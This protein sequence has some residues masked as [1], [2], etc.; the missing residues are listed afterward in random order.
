MALTIWE[1]GIAGIGVGLRTN[2]DAVLRDMDGF[3]DGA[4][5]VAAPR[6]ANELLDRALLTGERAVRDVYAL[7]LATIRKRSIITIKRARRGDLE[8]SFNVKGKGFALVDFNPRQT[9]NGVAVTIKG[10]R[11]VIAHTFLRRMPNGHVGVF[12]RGGYAA[13]FQFH[14][15][16][17]VKRNGK[18]TELP[19][20]ELYSFGPPDTFSHPE[21]VPKMLER[22]EEDAPKVMQREIRSAARGF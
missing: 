19:I 6:A 17:H 7:P 12:A 13:R 8:A 15:G 3:V 1:V 5:S 16:R 18:W 2:V 9:P 22:V 4:L 10:R 11:H 20:A 14:K 21:V